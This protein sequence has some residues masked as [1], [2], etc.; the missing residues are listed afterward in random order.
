M[1]ELYLLN[2]NLVL[3]C[4]EIE[5]QTR[6]GLLHCINHGLQE[7]YNDAFLLKNH[8]RPNRKPPGL[9]TLFW[10]RKVSTSAMLIST[11][12]ISSPSSELPPPE[13]TW[14]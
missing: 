13:L 9:G 12:S 4:L 1:K 8:C 7:T 2:K 11:T 10:E 3:W 6:L 5:M 14:H